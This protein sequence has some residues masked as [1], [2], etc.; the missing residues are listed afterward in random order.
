MLLLMYTHHN[1]RRRDLPDICV[2]PLLFIAEHP[3]ACT[4]AV[5][6][7]KT[8]LF[9]VHTELSYNS[10]VLETTCSYPPS[11]STRD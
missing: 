4:R 7:G 5:Q 6:L 11:Q 9:G 8:D 10:T 1:E 3:T 2:V